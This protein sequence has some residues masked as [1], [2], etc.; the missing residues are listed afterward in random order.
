MKK[1]FLCVL[2][3]MAALNFGNQAKAQVCFASVSPSITFDTVN[4]QVSFA[5]FNTSFGTYTHW[6]VKVA[7]FFGN[8]ASDTLSVNTLSTNLTLPYS[9]NC[10]GA[11]FTCTIWDTSS[12]FGCNTTDSFTFAYYNPN[13]CN[14]FGY[15]LGGTS[16]SFQFIAPPS[17]S[18]STYSWDFGDSTTSTQQNPT[19]TYSQFSGIYHVILTVTDPNGVICV[20]SQFVHVFGPASPCDA[21]FYGNGSDTVGAIFSYYPTLYGSAVAGKTVTWDFGDGTTSTDTS[22]QV[23]HVYTQPGTYTLH[24][25]I[26]DSTCTD[27]FTYLVWVVTPPSQCS[28]NLSVSTNN[29][30]LYM[31]VTNMTAAPGR[32]FTFSFF[33][34]DTANGS[35]QMSVYATQLSPIFKFGLLSNSTVLYSSVSFFDSTQNCYNYV[36]DS[37]IFHILGPQNNGALYGWVTG[38]DSV[39]SHYALGG[40]LFIIQYDSLAGTLNAIDTVSLG[41]GVLSPYGFYAGT[42]PAGQYLLKAVPDTLQFPNYLPAYYKFDPSGYPSSAMTWSDATY[43]NIQAGQLTNVVWGCPT[44]VVPPGP[45]FVGGN[46]S[47]GANKTMGVGDPMPGMSIMLLDAMKQPLGNVFTHSNGNFSYPSL[48]YGSYYLH[49]EHPGMATT[50]MPF[51]IDAS[52]PG[53]VINMEAG[54]AGIFAAGIEQVTLNGVNVSL[55]PNPTTDF[56]TLN[57]RFT[58][59]TPATVEVVDGAGRVVSSQRLTLGGT[60]TSNAT[61]NVANLPAGLYRVSVKTEGA[62][63]IS[64]PLSVVR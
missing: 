34:F 58:K 59:P 63:A 37:S 3:L 43:V 2:T 41:S 17:S 31:A 4:S 21:T 51:T 38:L 8:V 57:A 7:D 35:T 14:N 28:L 26:S 60:T 36:N 29:D 10:P 53:V 42:Y 46:V 24:H 40:N 30:T 47:Q 27:T 9:P 50:D 19:H 33:F 49:A 64:L 5:V 1:I 48:A 13:P 15:Y 61:I 44:G 25:S 32:T 45:G 39:T 12:A 52:N 6:S 54:S 20:V 22:M 55:Y 18:G 56:A 11:T 16:N 62:A 23:N